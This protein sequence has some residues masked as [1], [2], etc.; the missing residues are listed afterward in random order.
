MPAEN[1]L[2]LKQEATM[3][4]F[5][6]ASAAATVMF[7]EKLGRT[8]KVGSVVALTGN[9]GAVKTCLTKGIAKALGATVEAK[10]PTFTLI[11]VYEGRIPL[12]HF[13]CYRL[14]DARELEKLGY[15]EY[16]YG[17]GVSVVEWAD[18]VKELL[19][20]NSVYIEITVTGENGREIKI[21]QDEK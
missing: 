6:T 19:P 9:L 5:R 1:F 14:K 15:E 18:K 10:S 12:Y 13:D 11:N 21:E 16:F 8:L 20:K 4:L 7:G 17:N 2:C 3:P